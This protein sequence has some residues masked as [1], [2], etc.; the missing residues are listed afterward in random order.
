[1]YVVCRRKNFVGSRGKEQILVGQSI[2]QLYKLLCK[3]CRYI[4]GVR[5]GHVDAATAAGGGRGRAA[6]GAA[7][8]AC[9][10]T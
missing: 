2:N 10:T 1:M 6:P 7:S 5:D 4:L 9:D 3:K 8:G